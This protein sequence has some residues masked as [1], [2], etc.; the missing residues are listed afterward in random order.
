MW[1]WDV[2]QIDSHFTQ[3]KQLIHVLAVAN[4]DA[5]CFRCVDSGECFGI[6]VDYI[7]KFTLVFFNNSL[8]QNKP[9]RK[10]C[11]HLYKY[12]L[13]FII[14]CS[15]AT[16]QAYAITTHAQPILIN[17]ANRSS[18]KSVITNKAISH[19]IIRYQNT[20]NKNVFLKLP[21]CF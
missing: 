8:S 2:F 3:N 12:S 6:V 17:H 15:D 7:E 14:L 1:K 13:S 9:Q 18:K 10:A 11:N 4:L 20:S 21:V 5:I 16:T 19:R